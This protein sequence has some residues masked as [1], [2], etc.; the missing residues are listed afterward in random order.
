MI[1]QFRHTRVFTFLLTLLLLC[2][3]TNQAWA[4][5]V[6][7][8]ILTLPIDSVG[9]YNYHMKA[10]VHGWRLEAVKVVVNNQSTVELPAQYK[11]PLVTPGS[12]KY[13]K[14]EDVTK[15]SSGTAQNLFDNGPIKG[16]LYRINGEETPGDASDDA[17][18]DNGRFSSS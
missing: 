18:C 13:Y 5:T 8:H 4:A 10:I 17:T 16:V 3:G 14:A 15:Y 1:I 2:G 6:T 12:F 7:Y 11:S 9:R